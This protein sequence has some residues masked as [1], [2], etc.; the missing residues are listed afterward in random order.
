MG[1]SFNKILKRS[2][3]VFGAVI[4]GI[5]VTFIFPVAGFT[6]ISGVVIDSLS[7]K[8]LP[9]A[10]VLL[11]SQKRGTVSDAKGLFRFEKTTP[12]KDTLTVRYI[13]Y[14]LFH[15][16]IHLAG[17]A[18][19]LRIALQPKTIKGQAVEVTSWRYDLPISSLKMEP[20]LR[21][22]K[23]A[24]LN[25]V[26]FVLVPDI[27]RSLQ[28]LP[29]VT[30]A[31][32]ISPQF[33]VRGGNYDQNLVMLDEA[34]IYY[35][36]HIYG[37]LS[38]F[39]PDYIQDL[40][41]SPGGFSTRYGNRLSS[42]V[43]IQTA[44]PAP[45]FVN[46]VNLHLLGMDFTLGHL[47]R[48]KYGVILSA[49]M[50]HFDIY[51]KLAKETLPYSLTEFF[52]KFTWQPTPNQHG[53]FLA[54]I[55]R[56]A[57]EMTDETTEHLYSTVDTT[58]L[59][60]K[61]MSDRRLEFGN[62]VFSLIWRST[63]SDR[64][65]SR[66]QGTL[67]RYHNS[68]LNDFTAEFP[69]EIPEG[70]QASYATAAQRLHAENLTDGSD[71]E[72]RLEDFQIK[73]SAHYIWN[74]KI[75]FSFGA[76]HNRFQTDYGWTRFKNPDTT[77]LSF[78]F[79]HAPEEEF[80]F[81]RNFSVSALF[82]ESV[83]KLHP[84]VDFRPGIRVTNW[85]TSNLILE[86]RLNFQWQL[87]PQTS[88]KFAYGRFSQGV[89]TMLERGL[90]T[91]LP[92][93]FPANPPEI[94]DHFIFTA[95]H[96]PTDQTFLSLTGYYKNYSNLLRKGA[97][98]FF[99]TVPGKAYGFETEGHAR[100]GRL[101]LEGSYV[102]SHSLRRIDGFE[103][104]TNQDIRHRFQILTQLNLGR[105]WQ[106]SAFWELHSGQIYNPNEIRALY[107]SYSPPIDDS[108]Q[109]FE[110]FRSY[111]V[112]IQP[113]DI[114]YPYYHRLDVSL[115]KKFRCKTFTFVPYLSVRNVYNRKNVIY[116]QS[117]DYNATAPIYV[118]SDQLGDTGF[119]RDPFTLPILPTFGF[120]VYF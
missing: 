23:P 109:Q 106:L 19:K 115:H 35:P 65:T 20:G 55:T 77:W 117:L 76:E 92:L 75:D 47:F 46:R 88:F 100:W 112:E 67:T 98:S 99:Q 34:V 33:Y 21:I 42:V 25:S 66:F 11:L 40:L 87:N 57:E 54:F 85:S 61:K 28:M 101:E 22:L 110:S 71:I 45:D 36:F 44:V 116:Y 5:L 104:P 26:P 48:E 68:Y 53:Q 80:Q 29:G 32:D 27:S 97:A 63:F 60:Y 86:P 51:E 13:G 105:G 91:F 72:N 7:G 38:S 56:D 10:N 96:A 62:D 69:S 90:I 114:R 49:K 41:F 70:F 93:Y 30:A 31:N 73:A 64:L 95:R 89:A 79:D 1:N 58:K 18:L 103:V 108:E 16:E 15:Q 24:R 78:F 8:T 111:P 50:S 9:N 107:R 39:S 82:L 59:N 2:T 4:L 102:W 52:G 113:G 12:G 84:Q 83:L 74:E 37:L 17:K 94:A 43:N 14:H 81:N 3:A 120:Q 119:E 118:G 6:Q